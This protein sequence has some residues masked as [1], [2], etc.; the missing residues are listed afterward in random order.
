MSQSDSTRDRWHAERLQLGV[1][2]VLPC[3]SNT[4]GKAGQAG[5]RGLTPNEEV[6]HLV[7]VLRNQG[8]DSDD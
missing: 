2:Q 4:W 7:D 5:N 1:A 8:C 6:P 3:R